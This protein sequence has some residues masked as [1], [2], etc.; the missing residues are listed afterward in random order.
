VDQI[1]YSARL[2][3]L[4]AARVEVIQVDRQAAAGRVAVDMLLVERLD[5]VTRRLLRQV[6]VTTALRAK[7][8]M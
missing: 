7:E 3:L 8:I 4:V 6:K 2:H 5:Q 1:L